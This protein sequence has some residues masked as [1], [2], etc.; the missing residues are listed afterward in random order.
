MRAKL[1]DGVLITGNASKDAELKRVGEKQSP[2]TKWG[3]AVGKD[4]ED[5]VVFVNCEAWGRLAYKASEIQKGDPVLVIGKLESHEYQGK[6]Y[7]TVVA[8]FLQHIGKTE[9]HTQDKPQG[10]AQTVGMMPL[11]TD[12]DDLPF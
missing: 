7:H 12:D 3:V 9:N 1:G 6:T 8:E 2:N 11:L 10:E 5:K 4:A